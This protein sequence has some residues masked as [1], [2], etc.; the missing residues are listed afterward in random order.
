M[1]EH[2]NQ[3]AQ[4]MAARLRACRETKG[5]TLVEAAERLS[6]AA[7]EMVIHQRWTQWEHGQRLP[8]ADLA[9]RLAVLFGTDP[10]H[11]AESIEDAEHHD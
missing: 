2:A 7:G 6:E 4:V 11:F 8:T 3:V 10:G 1:S 9:A 5:W